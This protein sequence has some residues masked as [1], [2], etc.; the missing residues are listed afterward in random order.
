MR[1]VFMGASELGWECCRE[2]CS[3]PVE[4]VG[5][6][7]IPQQFRI[8]WSPTP[9]NNVQFRSFEDLAATH[10]VP[11]TYVTTKMSDPAYINELERLRPD[12]VL[13]IGWYYIVP[14]S[15][16]KIP[17]LGTVGIHAALLPKYRGGAPLVWALING[18]TQAGVS[19]FYFEDGVDNGDVIGQRA[20]P[21]E[22]EDDIAHVLQKATAASIDLVRTY[23]P[24]LAEERAPRIGQ[25]HSEATT[26]PQRRPEDGIIDWHGLTATQVYNWVRAQTRPY[27]GAFTYLQKERV[28]IWRSSIC[29]IQSD[30]ATPGTLATQVPGH[31]DALGV[32]CASG[33]MLLVEEVGLANGSVL[34]GAD[35]MSYAN[36]QS[37]MS[38]AGNAE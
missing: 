8:S 22:G 4:V 28:T 2:L 32:W 21:L 3:L 36:L 29:D 15:L 1:V 18:E 24:L 13:V 19:L 14:R 6:F 12:L 20:F 16:R 38:F 11:L 27:P 7:S 30:A 31:D 35:F 25:D 26:M 34:R 33:T 17:R 5:I 9:V 23:I 10:G 37:G